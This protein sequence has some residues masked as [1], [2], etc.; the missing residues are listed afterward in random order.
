MWRHAP[1]SVRLACKS[2]RCLAWQLSD[3]TTLVHAA[4]WAETTARLPMS[5]F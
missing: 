2:N 4:P 1:W 3:L 5:R